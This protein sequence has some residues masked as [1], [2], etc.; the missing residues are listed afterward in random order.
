MAPGSEP[1]SGNDDANAGGGGGHR[2]DAVALPKR[3]L[4]T[5]IAFAIQNLVIPPVM[6]VRHTKQRLLPAETSPTLTKTYPVRPKLP[7]RIFFPK[8]YDRQ[9]AKPL[10]LLFSIHGG[11]FVFGEPS[12]NDVFNSIF[13][14]KHSALVVA[15]NYAKAPANPFPGPRL[16]L[17]ALIDAVLSDPELTP[18][19]DNDRVGIT[20]FSAGGALAL[21]VSQIPAVRD[22]ITA[23]LVPI[24]PA[25]DLS[26]GHTDKAATRRYK[27]AL[28]GT[29]SKPKDFLLPAAPLFDWACK[30]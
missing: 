25:T 8:S 14:Q 24:Y 21:A 16:D 27:A 11:G 30:F 9:S 22:R 28:G 2:K 19:I 20:G 23:G 15:L 26:K 17:E 12:D 18:H 10:P 3:A 7:I 1:R 4:F 13:C 29:R 5:T 6:A